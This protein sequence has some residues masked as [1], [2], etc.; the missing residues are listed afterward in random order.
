MNLKKT[1]IL[2]LWISIQLIILLVSAY[3]IFTSNHHN[4]EVLFMSLESILVL[5]TGIITLYLDEI[6]NAHSYFLTHETFFVYILFNWVFF[7]IIGYI[8][9]FIILPKLIN[10]CKDNGCIIRQG[11]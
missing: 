9:W 4:V 6:F 11:F 10:K 3:Y 8:Q 7:T 2:E 1:F 5:P